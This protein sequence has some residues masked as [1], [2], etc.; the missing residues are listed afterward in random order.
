MSLSTG[1]KVTILL[2]L[3]EI[4]SLLRVIHIAQD[5][6][7]HLSR[8]QYQCFLKLEKKLEVK[9]ERVKHDITFEK[10]QRMF[11]VERDEQEGQERIR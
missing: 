9:R 4:Q 11:K 5:M 7:Y 6:D 8:K 3:D 1:N 2:D 10:D